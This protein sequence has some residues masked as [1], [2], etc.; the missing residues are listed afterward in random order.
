[1]ERLD[2][3]PGTLDMLILQSLSTHPAHGYAI[4]QHM[5]QASYGALNVEQ[6][7]LYPALYRLE[8]RGWVRSRWAT[9]ATKRRVKIYRLTAAGRRRLD[10]EADRWKAFASIVNRIMRRPR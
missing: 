10:Q 2:M 7:S 5:L 9:S 3:M 4:A 1:M 8:R 6:G